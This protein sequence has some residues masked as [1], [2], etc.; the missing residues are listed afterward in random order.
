MHLVGH[1]PSW[2]DSKAVRKTPEAAGGHLGGGAKSEVIKRLRQVNFRFKWAYFDFGALLVHLEPKMA[3][4]ETQ[5][6]DLGLH[7]AIFRLIQA[8][9]RLK[10]VNLGVIP[11]NL[12]LI[13]ANLKLK[14]ANLKIIWANSRD[15]TNFRL[16]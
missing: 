13:W 7:W 12:M 1:A 4:L 3:R 15:R 5:R 16:I 11:N 14:Q 2:E 10:W 6:T 8:Y 9:L